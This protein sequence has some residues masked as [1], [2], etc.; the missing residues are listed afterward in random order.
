MD[1]ADVTFEFGFGQ[2]ILQTQPAFRLGF[3]HQNAVV[4]GATVA[5]RFL[6]D[7]DALRIFADKQKKTNAEGRRETFFESPPNS[8]A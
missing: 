5:V 8:W 6:E 2:Q 1:D 3:R 4:V 7:Q